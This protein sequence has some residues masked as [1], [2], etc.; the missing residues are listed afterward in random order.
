MEVVNRV[1]GWGPEGH[2]TSFSPTLKVKFSRKVGRDIVRMKRAIEGADRSQSPVTEAEPRR[3]ARLLLSPPSGARLGR[4]C[5]SCDC[6][7]PRASARRAPLAP[8]DGGRAARNAAVWVSWGWRQSH[9]G[10]GGRRPR[11]GAPRPLGSCRVQCGVVTRRS[12]GRVGSPGI[13]GRQVG[14][15]A[16]AGRPRH[17]V[18]SRSLLISSRERLP[19][20]GPRFLIQERGRS[21]W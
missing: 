17:S 10:R 2:L 14:L 19:G 13:G 4:L 16:P 15:C 21:G 1:V 8:A 5:T 9:P 12:V 18:T 20:R 6:K 11:E 3:K 7:T